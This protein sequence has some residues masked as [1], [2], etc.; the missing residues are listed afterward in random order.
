MTNPPRLRLGDHLQHLKR[1]R[2]PERLDTLR[3]EVSAQA[4][5]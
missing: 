3:Q 1:F 2:V 5:T 4:L